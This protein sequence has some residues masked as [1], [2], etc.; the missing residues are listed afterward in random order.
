MKRVL[1]VFLVALGMFLAFG[2]SAFA[3]SGS[4]GAMLNQRC[5]KDPSLVSRLTAAERATL[6]EYV[7]PVSSYCRI[8]DARTGKTLSESDGLSNSGNTLGGILPMSSQYYTWYPAVNPC[9]LYYDCGEKNVFGTVLWNMRI[10]NTWSWNPS[11]QKLNSASYSG[12]TVHTF[13]IG[14]AWEGVVTQSTSQ[15]SYYYQHLHQGHFA[16]NLAGYQAAHKYPIIDFTD[17]ANSPA[18]MTWHWTI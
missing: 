12:P 4:D 15:G 7:T 1:L 11:T 2:G 17:W 16:F 8:V 6:L 10:D 5:L 9:S 18:R 3:T 14:W 13:V